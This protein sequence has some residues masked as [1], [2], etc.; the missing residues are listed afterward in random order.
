METEQKT[1]KSRTERKKRENRQKI[2]KAAMDLFKRQGFDN[3]TMEQ[4]AEE[5]DIARKTLY[6]YFPVKEAIA[7]EYI[8]EISKEHLSESLEALRDLPDTRSRLLKVLNDRYKWVEQN[9]EITKVVLCYRFNN[10]YQA[11]K[12]P[13]ETGTQAIMAEII[14]QGQQAGEIKP[15]I[16][17]DLMVMYID[18]LRGTMAWEWVNDPAKFELSEKIAILV[19]MVLYGIGLPGSGKAASLS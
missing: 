10:I 11:G 8:R 4:I 5:A 13:E 3:T 7:D 1:G 16:S 15:D 2:I 18:L 17:V 19:D 14:R 9:T 6:N 12:K